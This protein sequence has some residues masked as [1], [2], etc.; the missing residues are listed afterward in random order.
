[1]GHSWGTSWRQSRARMMSRMPMQRKRLPYRQNMWLSIWW[2]DDVTLN[3]R[4]TWEKRKVY[5]SGLR[6]YFTCTHLTRRPVSPHQCVGCNVATC[7]AAVTG[8]RM[9]W[10]GGS[11]FGS[12]W[13]PLWHL[14]QIPGWRVGCALGNGPGDGGGL[15]GECVRLD[16]TREDR[17]GSREPT[18][19]KGPTNDT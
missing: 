17:Q 11:R 4:G 15:E 1:M 16:R 12:F 13:S 10:A 18:Y 5:F 3:Y 2:R 7:L 14:G 8:V 9:W 6:N 19:I